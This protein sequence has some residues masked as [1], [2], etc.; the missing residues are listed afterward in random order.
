V[1][2]FGEIQAA[3]KK[4][5]AAL[6]AEDIPF[7]LGG[8]LATWSYGGPESYHDV[9]LMLREVDARRAQD[10]L[11]AV[12]MRPVDP[13]ED[14]LLKAYD[15]EVLVD[16]IFAP[17]GVPVDDALL[18]RSPD[19]D[20]A[21][22]RMKVLRLE[23]AFTM[24]LLAMHENYFDFPGMLRVARA[25]REQC[26]WSEVRARTSESPFAVAFLCLLEH[27]HVIEPERPVRVAS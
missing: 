11:A 15:G 1:S 6:Q 18:E 20:V 26:D 7:V 19:R 27:L 16:L 10:V 8:G 4:A 13:P 25:V 22:M 14:W 9:D 2:A 3:L 17:K 5:A 12:G 21:A 24:Q 23:D